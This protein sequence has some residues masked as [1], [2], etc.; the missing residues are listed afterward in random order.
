[1]LAAIAGVFH[2]GYGLGSY[3]DPRLSTQVPQ[4]IS[5]VTPTND[6]PAA[7]KRG[8]KVASGVYAIS[9]FLLVFQYLI[10]LYQTR[11]AGRNIKPPLYAMCGLFVSGSLFFIAMAVTWHEFGQTKPAAILRTTFWALGWT[12]EY[13]TSTF[14]AMSSSAVLLEQEYWTERFAALTLVVLGEGVLGLFESYRTAFIGPLGGY[15][16]VTI[17]IVVAAV[18]LYRLLYRKPYNSTAT[19]TQLTTLLED[20]YFHNFSQHLRG[21]T[22]HHLVWGF[23]HLPMSLS[24]LLLTQCKCPKVAVLFDRYHPDGLS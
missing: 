10:V 12:I 9:R 3:E 11:K 6:T 17:G 24:L 2:I 20:L 1:M 18:A 16:P 19:P 21:G 13:A 23:L 15:S 7:V 14:S 8:L 4:W 22:G 5:P